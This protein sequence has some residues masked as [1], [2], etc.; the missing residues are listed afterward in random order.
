MHA[1]RPDVG[2]L[3]FEDINKGKDR[4][5]KARHWHCSCQRGRYKGQHKRLLVEAR[6]V[7]CASE[8]H[9]RS[10]A[11]SRARDSRATASEC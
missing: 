8:L 9:S 3:C 10:T 7:E 5:L 2:P 6:R 11:S 1:R 4:K